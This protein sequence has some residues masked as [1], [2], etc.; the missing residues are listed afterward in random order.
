MFFQYL[1]QLVP[2][3]ALCNS[4][5]ID[6]HTGIKGDLAILKFHISVIY[7]SFRRLNLGKLRHMRII[8]SES[9]CLNEARG[10]QA[11]ETIGFARSPHGDP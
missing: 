1:Y 11:M 9:P 8:K 2:Q 5:K 7:Y 10:S 6:L 3:I 4:A